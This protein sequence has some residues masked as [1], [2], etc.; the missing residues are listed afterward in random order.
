MKRMDLIKKDRK[1]SSNV[2]AQRV[3]VAAGV[4][5]V[6]AAIIASAVVW[7][8]IRS[9][10][11]ASPAPLL[12]RTQA[13][14]VRGSSVSKYG[15]SVMAYKS[16]PFAKPPIGNLRFKRPELPD[17]QTTSEPINTENY[18]KSCWS[19]TKTSPSKYYG[20]DC[21]YLNV[22]VPE[23]ESGPFPVI[24]WIHGGGFVAGSTFPE[25]LK[26]VHQGNVLSV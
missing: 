1:P 20:E 17:A 11:D 25:P 6:L 19:A 16:I 4:L 14:M 2:N 3:L 22:Y 21:L 13:G 8:N 10:A 12:V 23:G 24:V 15:Y 18:K 9:A 26:M 5:S 7:S